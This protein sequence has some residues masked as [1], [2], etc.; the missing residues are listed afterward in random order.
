MYPKKEFGD[1]SDYGGGKISLDVTDPRTAL[2]II[3]TTQQVY[4]WV[5]TN[6]VI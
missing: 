4:S 6:I 1:G 2:K 3:V 5:F